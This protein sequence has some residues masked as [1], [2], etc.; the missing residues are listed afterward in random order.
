MYIYS[1]ASYH[2]DVNDEELLNLKDEVKISCGAH[3]RRIDRFIQ[4]ALIG[5]HRCIKGFSLADN[6]GLYVASSQGAKGNISRSLEQI[7]K[8]KQP[9]MPLNF[10][11]MVG[12]AASF[13]IAKMFN[14][15]GVNLFLTRNEFTFEEALELALLDINTGVSNMA[16]VGTVD[17]CI[18]P[19]AHHRTQLRIAPDR[20]LGE[21]SHWMLIGN[22]AS[23]LGK[24]IA[25]IASLEYFTDYKDVEHWLASILEAQEG[26]LFHIA[27]GLGLQESK[28]SSLSKHTQC[29]SSDDYTIYAGFY[30]SLSGLG[31][32]KTIKDIDAFTDDNVFLHI[33]ENRQGCFSC[34]AF[35]RPDQATTTRN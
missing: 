32:I 5:S 12:N 22:E 23:A 28:K 34:M 26:K 6:T 31:L 3:I 27:F 2:N 18:T 4:L 17:E 13:Y 1:C 8:E 20:Q 30:E 7:Y 9:L 33:D 25:E 19:L 16:L 29:K 24:P 21:G 10:I 11:N 35:I 15:H 14:T